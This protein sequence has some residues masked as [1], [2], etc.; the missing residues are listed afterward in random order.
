METSPMHSNLEELCAAEFER[1]VTEVRGAKFDQWGQASVDVPWGTGWGITRAGVP[2]LIDNIHAALAA[3]VWFSKH[4]PAWAIQPLPMGANCI[5][6]FRTTGAMYLLGCWV[7]SLQMLNYDY[8]EHPQLY[9][10]CCGATAHSNAPKHVR[11]HPT[12]CKEFP[13]KELPGLCRRL[14]WFNPAESH[15]L[16]GS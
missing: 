8:I 1:Y 2:H 14:I 6:L 7:F 4:G 13:P 10:F 12:L 3:K 16:T 5:A 11:E 15:R 9:D